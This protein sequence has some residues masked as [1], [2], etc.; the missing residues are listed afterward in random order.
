M[1]GVTLYGKPTN[2][3]THY[4]VEQVFD[5]MK[6]A[7]MERFKDQLAEDPSA[8][9]KHIDD[10]ELK[11]LE[12]RYEHLKLD[13]FL[14]TGEKR[15]DG[16]ANN[17]TMD[18]VIYNKYFTSP[19]EARAKEQEE[20]QK[21]YMAAISKMDYDGAAK[22]S[23]RIVEL[24]GIAPTDGTDDM[25]TII[26]CLDEMDMNAYATKIVIDMHP[27]KWDLTLPKN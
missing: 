23:N 2:N 19:A 12:D 18:E 21:K 1:A 25:K 11:K 24:S 10:P 20:L 8:L 7:Y 22:I 6:K 26:K 4:S 15:K 27:S 13:Y 14:L 16:G 5:K 17:L 3:A 9:Q